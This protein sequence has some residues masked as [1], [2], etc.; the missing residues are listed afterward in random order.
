LIVEFIRIVSFAFRLFGSMFIGTALIMVMGSILPILL[1]T[2]FLG[3]EFAAGIIQAF[4]FL[5]LIT[6][7]TS[8]AVEHGES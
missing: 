7:F 6:V 1:P 2:V 5:M 3:F 4:V 8:L